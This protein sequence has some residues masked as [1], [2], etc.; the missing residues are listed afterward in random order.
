M[1]L[2]VRLKLFLASFAV[3]AISVTIGDAYLTHAI[4]RYLTNDIEQDL[5]VRAKLVALEAGNASIAEGDLEA[6]DHLAD[7]FGG[8]AD[9]RVTLVASDGRVLGD[10]E[11]DAAKISA[12]ENHATREEVATALANGHGRSTRLSATVRER[13]MY[14]AVPFF[15]RDGRE[16]GVAR[17]AKP[18]RMVDEAIGAVH[19]IVL[20]AFIIALALAVFLSSAAA[21]RM[22]AVVRS[23]TETARRMKSGDLDVRTH[24]SGSDELAELGH[25]LDQLAGSLENTLAELRTER[26]LQR[27]ILE[28]MHEGVLVLDAE[29]RVVT[30]N[31]ALR[32]MLLLPADAVGKMLVEVVRHA[33]LHMLLE[34]AR[35]D[36]QSS[37]ELE[38]PGIK[39]RRLLVGATALHDEGDEGMIAVIVDVTDVRRLESLR[40]D[41]VAN[42]SHEL[43]TPVAA[44]RSAAETLRG[45]V[46]DPNAAVRFIDMIERNAQRLQSL[47]EDLLHL[48]RIESKE[49][50]IK[51]ERVDITS[52]FH[53]VVG[54]FRDR[55]ERKQIRL[56]MRIS[57]PAPTLETDG[58]ALEQILSNLVENAVKYCPAGSSVTLCAETKGEMVRIAVEDTGPGIGEKHLPRLFER[59]YRVDASRSR[60]LGGTGLGLSIVKHL[61]EALGGKISVESQIGKGSTFT[62]QLRTSDWGA[63]NH[64]AVR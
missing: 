11:V 43:R 26:D 14:A 39:P 28:G 19:R 25:A 57:H 35:A 47:I 44:V 2:G 4:D 10:S 22:S 9:G 58:R 34:M 20:F 51:R 6:W 1:R 60:E 32:E 61:T 17:V 15:A 5:F 54:L 36:G 64:V 23:L 52:L 49:F 62:V 56:E 55:A 12:L 13:M 48:S 63:Q 45:A 41:F 33:E 38:L 59:F 27:R 29:A 3:I 18:L 16:A 37:G 30:M 40:R 24:I 7:R 53:I 21:Q 42:V 8:V 31:H 50:R 46:S